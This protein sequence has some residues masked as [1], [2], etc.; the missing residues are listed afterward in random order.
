MHATQ[1][2]IPH[3]IAKVVGLSD[4]LLL[5]REHDVRRSQRVTKEAQLAVEKVERYRLLASALLD[6]VLDDLKRVTI[7]VGVFTVHTGPAIKFLTDGRNAHLIQQPPSWWLPKFMS[8]FDLVPFSR[9][10]QGFWIAV[11][12]PPT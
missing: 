7:G 12:A 10:S 5:E 1:R 4:R 8:R 11:E 3:S 9:M 2:T 6:N